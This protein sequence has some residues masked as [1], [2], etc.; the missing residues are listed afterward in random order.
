MPPKMNISQNR[1][2]RPQNVSTNLP[3]NIGI[4]L[5]LVH[6]VGNSAGPGVFADISGC[7]GKGHG[8]YSLKCEGRSKVSQLAI[9]WVLLWTDVIFASCRLL[10]PIVPR[11]MVD[12]CRTL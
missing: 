10:E 8:G 7:S 4:L 11:G 12:I 3:V 1:Y 2:S 5:L 9:Y 6:G